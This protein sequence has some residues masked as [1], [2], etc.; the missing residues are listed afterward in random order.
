MGKP[1]EK[2]I[3]PAKEKTGEKKPGGKNRICRGKNR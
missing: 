2:T 3:V 1:A